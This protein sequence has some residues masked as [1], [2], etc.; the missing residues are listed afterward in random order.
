MRAAHVALVMTLVA[1]PGCI[2]LVGADINNKYV[3]RD[4]KRF[5][6]TGNP[7]ISL[8]TFDGSIEVRA[9][10][11]SEVEVIIEKRAPSKESAASI[12][13]EAEQTGNRISVDARVPKS[14]S[15]GFHIGSRSAKLIVSAP[16]SSNLVA[17]SGD[18]SID[19][20]RI[21]GRVELRSGDGSIHARDVGGDVKVH[22]G[23][24]A[25]KVERVKGALDVDTGD[26]SVV[27]SGAFTALRARTGDGGIDIRVEPGSSPTSDWDI[28]TGDGSINLELPDGFSGE[29]DAHTGDGRVHMDNVTLTNVTGEIGKS[30]VRGRIGSGGR[31]VRVRTGDGSITLR[32]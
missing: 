28:S 16:A 20:D 32:R 25:I 27:A 5:S 4:E 23:D 11:R 7:D 1:A 26:G 6:T 8:S 14:S 17:K 3:E 30:T 13:V 15:F 19:V 31:S 21:T 2:D 22:T 10:D 9:W 29:L 18:G 24:G 12:Q